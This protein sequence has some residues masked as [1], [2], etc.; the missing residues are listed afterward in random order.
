MVEGLYLGGLVVLALGFVVY[1]SR[2]RQ[3]RK[4]LRAKASFHPHVNASGD[5]MCFT[6][7]KPLSALPA[8]NNKA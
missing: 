4:R 7:G 5:F 1:L 8:R 3:R 2:L 6:L